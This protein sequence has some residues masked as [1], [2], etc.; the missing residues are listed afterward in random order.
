MKRTLKQRIAVAIASIIAGAACALLA[1]CLLGRALIFHLVEGR[2][3]LFASHIVAESEASSDEA[4][5]ALNNLRA[6]PNSSCS[7]AEVIYLGLQIYQTEYLK[8][9]GRIRNGK[10]I[11]SGIFGRLNPPFPLPHPDFSQP[12]GSRAY[13]NPAPFKAGNRSVVV[14]QVG[15]VYVAFGA[16]NQEYLGPIV[17]RYAITVLEGIGQHVS[18]QS[19]AWVRIT[20]PTRTI[21]GQGRSGGDLY[22]TRCSTRNFNCVTAFVSTAGALRLERAQLLLLLAMGAILGA[23]CGFICSLLYHRSRSLDRQLRR[24]IRQDKIRLVYQP[25]VELASG[26]IV[27]AEALARWTDEDNY[28]VSPDVFIRIAEERGFVHAITRLVVRRALRDF[29]PL[30]CQ[31]AG[32]RLSINVTADDLSDPGFLPMLDHAQHHATVPAQSLAIE[33]TESSTARN[34]VAVETIRSLRQRGYGVH[35]DDFGT[36]YSSLAYLHELSVDAIKI[37]RAFTQAIGTGAVTV[38]ILPQILSMAKSLCLEVIVEGIETSQQAEY[39]A[40]LAQGWFFGRPVPAD[41]FLQRL[42]EEENKN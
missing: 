30:L 22:A 14:L 23:C 34:H 5:G 13:W 4:R 6:S 27:G 3:A 32:F 25:I 31:R 28:A 40:A 36:G 24:A 37:D 33:I 26:R 11:C 29:G 21:N 18:W 15:D 39:F 1:S 20:D 7:D 35:I 38:S 42:A 19:G 17:E 8:D 12:D 41:I 16:H 2:L 9:A 10:I